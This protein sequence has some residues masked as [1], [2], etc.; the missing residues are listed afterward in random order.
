MKKLI[1]LILLL[2][3][4]V[5][6]LAQSHGGVLMVDEYDKMYTVQLAV[7]TTVS[8]AKV[9][10]NYKKGIYWDID[11]TTSHTPQKVSCRYTVLFLWHAE[12]AISILV[13]PYKTISISDLPKYGETKDIYYLAFHW[14]N[15]DAGDWEDTDVIGFGDETREPIMYERF[16]SD[17]VFSYKYLGIRK[18][19]TV[20]L[21]KY[22]WMR[23]FRWC[24]LCDDNYAQYKFNIYKNVLSRSFLIQ[25]IPNESL[26]QRQISNSLFG[27]GSDWFFDREEI[28]SIEFSEL[29][30]PMVYPHRLRFSE[31]VTY[32][33]KYVIRRKGTNEY[34]VSNGDKESPVEFYYI[35]H[36]LFLPTS[37][38]KYRITSI[39]GKSKQEF[40]RTYKDDFKPYQSS[41]EK[42]E[43]KEYKENTKKEIQDEWGVRK[44]PY[45][46][47]VPRSHN[48]NLD[49]CY[50]NSFY[51]TI[52]YNLGRNSAKIKENNVVS[53]S[54]S[55]ICVLPTTPVYDSVWN[56]LFLIKHLVSKKGN[57]YNISIDT[58]TTDVCSS[59]ASEVIEA[60]K[61]IKYTPAKSPYKDEPVN[62]KDSIFILFQGV[63]IGG[64]DFSK[65]IYDINKIDNQREKEYMTMIDYVCGKITKP[66]S[67]M[68]KSVTLNVIINEE[69]EIVYVER[70]NFIDD[71]ITRLKLNF[72]SG[73]KDFY[74]ATMTKELQAISNAFKT[75]PNVTPYEIDGKRVPVKI[76]LP[77]IEF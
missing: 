9:F 76:T 42:Y 6:S 68:G 25:D 62:T 40:L 38:F 77:K 3:I 57:V 54:V 7:D 45:R 4:A 47:L 21:Y 39:N 17:Y 16:W 70:S 15:M 24:K 52:Y 46:E 65:K 69:G 1:L 71:E 50:K 19:E 27:Y 32:D 10:P 49:W 41:S 58:D 35:P 63:Q 75:L 73:Y 56:K 72:A 29:N 60:V 53:E 43:F 66:Q 28:L 18:G 5:T 61:N 33:T 11:P 31:T 13:K 34:I 23:I 26:I 37:S 14:R 22:Y 64:F 30:R 8:I 44:W 51:D 12:F 20:Q 36:V 74:I 55:Q 48:N 2:N 67:L 59:S